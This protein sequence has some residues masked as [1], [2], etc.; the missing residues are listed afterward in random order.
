MCCSHNNGEIVKAMSVNPPPKRPAVPKHTVPKRGSENVPPP[1]L[2]A[3]GDAR[4]S[5]LAGMGAASEP[6]E[7]VETKADAPGLVSKDK[8][9]ESLAYTLD[10]IVGQVCTYATSISSVSCN[11]VCCL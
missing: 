5:L 4:V 8:L 6:A 11:A 1:A 7:A 2:N 3:Q 10:Y 9:P